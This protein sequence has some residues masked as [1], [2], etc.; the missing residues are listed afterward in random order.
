[1]GQPDDK[2][3]D[4][5]LKRYRGLNLTYFPHWKV[6]PWEKREK[7]ARVH[8]FLSDL[9][10]FLLEK[11]WTVERSD[12]NLRIYR[13]GDKSGFSLRVRNYIDYFGVHTVY[14]VE[15]Q[16]VEDRAFLGGKIVADG[17]VIFDR[18]RRMA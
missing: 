6:T 1:M 11:G 5:L 3:I 9:E 10:A 17:E 2:R 7:V 4:D 13:F 15:M 18:L 16:F 8:A 14:L 12:E